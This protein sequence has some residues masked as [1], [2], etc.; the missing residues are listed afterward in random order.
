M[1]LDGL[2]KRGAVQPSHIG[3]MQLPD[4]QRWAIPTPISPTANA[5][6]RLW[7][8]RSTFDIAKSTGPSP[9]LRV[10][11]RGPTLRSDRW[12]TRVPPAAPRPCGT[13]GI[14]RCYEH[15]VLGSLKCPTCRRG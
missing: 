2:P 5:P 12:S 3:F 8:D 4:V 10:L 13:Y 6:D 9:H 1:L 14:E 11:R 15:F 7:R